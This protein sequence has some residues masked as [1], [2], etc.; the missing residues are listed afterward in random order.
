MSGR[1]VLVR[2]A[3]CEAGPLGPACLPYLGEGDLVGS[4]GVVD[5]ALSYPTLPQPIFRAV[6]MLFASC[7]R[8]SE[9]AAIAA[10]SRTAARWM[11]APATTLLP[12]PGC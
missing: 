10:H 6:P 9:V 8:P 4:D 2:P 3:L 12:A 7:P 1:A 5:A 11:I